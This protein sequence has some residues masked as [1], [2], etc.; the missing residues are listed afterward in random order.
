MNKYI[1]IAIIIVLVLVIFGCVFSEPEMQMPMGYPPMM[2]PLEEAVQ[3][4]PI[5]DAP[6]VT[7]TTEPHK[8]EFPQ[9]AELD[10]LDGVSNGSSRQIPLESGYGGYKL[11]PGGIFDENAYYRF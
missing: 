4:S 5:V 2:M 7:E 11:G 8:N 10:I 6:T 9:G 3:E 1:Q